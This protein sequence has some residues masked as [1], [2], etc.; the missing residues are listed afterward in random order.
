MEGEMRVGGVGGV[1]WGG[2]GGIKDQWMVCGVDRENCCVIL[3]IY[4]PHLGLINRNNHKHTNVNNT[5]KY[6]FLLQQ[7]LVQYKDTCYRS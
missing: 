7:V 5:E 3:T 2:F 6:S 4:G 1:G